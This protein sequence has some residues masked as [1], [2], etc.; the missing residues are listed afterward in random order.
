MNLLCTATPV[1][2]DDGSWLLEKIDLSRIDDWP[3][4]LQQQ[5]RDLFKRYSHAFS[6]D[7]LDLGRA[8]MVKNYIK[9]T[10]PIP[11]K[12][13]YRGIPPQLYNEVREH[14]QEMLRLGAIRK[15]R[16]K[17]NLPEPKKSIRGNTHLI[18][19]LL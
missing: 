8:K 12:E 7:D 13:R 5:A 2:D 15:V 6:K 3:V 16:V 18:V 4:S 19:L 17:T 11:F 9:L 10:D 14:L 1:E